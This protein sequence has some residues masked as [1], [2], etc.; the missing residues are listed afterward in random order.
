MMSGAVLALTRGRL[1]EAA[2][3]LLQRAGIEPVEP[4]QGTRRLLIESSYPGLNL[5]V[6]RGLDV[7]TTVSRGAAQIGIV[8]QDLLMEMPSRDIYE[9]LDL[10]I[11]RCHIMT[12]AL[13]GA[14]TGCDKRPGNSVVVAAKL[15][16]VA[17][18][19]YASCGRPADII[20]MH[21]GLEIAPS[22]GLSD[23]ILDIVDTGETL[24]ANGLRPLAKVTDCSARLI[25]N[26][27]AMKT[28]PEIG[29]FIDAIAGAVES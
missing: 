19:F 7:I 10:S 16:N 17:R 28:M 20:R 29:E 9:L 3:I 24:R 12:A 21:G 5:L 23:E 27:A 6:V 13:E 1:L 14:V 26:K 18:A 22:L 15:V 4:L 8:G 2:Q 25:V 11:G